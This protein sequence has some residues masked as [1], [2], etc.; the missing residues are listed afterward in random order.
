LCFTIC[1]PFYK[2]KGDLSWLHF[3]SCTVMS[4][5]WKVKAAINFRL[6]KPQ[7]Q[8]LWFLHVLFHIQMDRW[9]K[10]S[11]LVLPFLTLSPIRDSV[12]AWFYR[13]T[14]TGNRVIFQ[15]YWWRKTSGALLC[16]IWGTS[17]H[18]SRTTNVPATWRAS[19]H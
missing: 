10:M 4:M 9:V 7:N 3:N 16:I 17:R 18:L 5:Q 8:R 6:G 12:L 15:L 13:H 2:K 11:Y 19:S 14:F 1:V